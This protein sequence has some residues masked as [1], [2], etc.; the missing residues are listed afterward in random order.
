MH[1]FHL[2]QNHLKQM[3]N[4]P[5]RLLE[6]LEAIAHAVRNTGQGLALIGLGS[7]GVERGRLDQYSDLD[8]YVIVQPG[9]KNRFIEQVDWL[10]AAGSI[11][12]NFLNSKDGRKILYQDGIFVEFA[13]FEPAEMPNVH[14]AE[15]QLVWY[16]P[17]FDLS[18]AVPNLPKREKRLEDE[19][20]WK[21][22]EILT[23]LYVGLLRYHR[24]EKLSASRFIQG[25]AV[26][27]ILELAPHLGTPHPAF[28]DPFQPERRFE[29]RYPELA[30]HLPDFVPGYAHTPQA[31]RAI[32]TFLE[33]HFEV[34]PFI[35]NAILNLL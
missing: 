15:G 13:I 34:D 8:F 27:R 5:Q 7:V 17:E 18:L 22:G 10:E 16:A 35:K 33:Q 20:L 31:A 9:K 4:H 21:L 14:F 28:A 24:G 29:R 26:D 1:P 12:Y 11:G 19:V 6:R 3:S 30:P 25:Y 23:N 32:L 2:K